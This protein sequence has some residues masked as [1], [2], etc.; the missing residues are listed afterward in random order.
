MGFFKSIFGPSKDEIWGQI[1]QDIDGEYN[2]AGFFGRD[3]LKYRHGEWEIHLDTF[4]RSSNS[5]QHQS[6]TTYTRMRVPFKNKDQLYFK[7]FPENFFSPVGKFFGLQD[8]QIGDSFFDDSFVIKGNNE[9]RIKEFLS[10]SRVRELIQA[11]PRVHLEVKDDEGW[12]GASFPAGVDELYFE[13]YGV[14]KD[15]H[16]VKLLFELFTTILDRLVEIDSAYE[17]AP[18]VNL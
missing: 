10:D 14:I 12:F 8:I 3:V 18:G 1:A 16:T 9:S 15:P 13:T 2:D 5:G 6:S 17:S 11:Q 7:I 4:T